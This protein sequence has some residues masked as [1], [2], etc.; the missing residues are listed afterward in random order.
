MHVHSNLHINA[1][2]LY[3][4]TPTNATAVS[5]PCLLFVLPSVL[6]HFLHLAPSSVPVKT[7]Y[8]NVRSSSDVICDCLQWSRNIN[9]HHLQLLCY[10]Y[11]YCHSQVAM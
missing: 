11:N 2:S 8:G 5:C 7:D 4:T 1:Y 9:L 10:N 3:T 6:L